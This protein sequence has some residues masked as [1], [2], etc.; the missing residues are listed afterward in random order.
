MPPSAVLDHPLA[1]VEDYVAFLSG[2]SLP[3]L[4]HT[5]RQ[6]DEAAAH[7]DRATARNLSA[8]ILHDPL[9]A[10]KVLYYIQPLRGKSLRS[11]IN[12]IGGAVMM[13]GVEPFFN[14]FADLTTVE[15]RLQPQPQAMLGLLKL[16]RR[17]QRAARYANDWAF[18][19][20]DLNVEE[21][22]LAALLHDLSEMLIWV[23]AP[24]LALAMRKRQAADPSRRSAD[25][26]REVLGIDLRDL[27]LALAR[28]WHLPELLLTLMD[29]AHAEHPRVRTVLLAVNLARHSAQGWDDA[30]LPDDYKE[31][32]TLLNLSEA[33]VID[34]LR[35]IEPEA[36]PNWAPEG[37][38]AGDGS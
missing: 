26:Q 25:V 1:H 16:I 31:I 30:A 7:I 14:T 3:V 22:T 21:V 10:T 12:T 36:A 13:L 32:G 35:R 38:A 6:L 19:R 34:R 11:E 9:M 28:A 24:T 27:Q 17:V 5:R 2:S 23:F 29:D 4:R 18:W 8:I 33:A 37:D 20:H 15:D